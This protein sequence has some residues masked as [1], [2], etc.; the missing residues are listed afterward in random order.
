MRTGVCSDDS[1]RKFLEIDELANVFASLHVA[2]AFSVRCQDANDVKGVSRR[3]I[4]AFVRMTRR[5]IGKRN[6][7]QSIYTYSFFSADIGAVFTVGVSLF[8]ARCSKRRPCWLKSDGAGDKIR[9][10]IG[11]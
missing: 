7:G 3:T 10:D 9:F 4:K 5:V 1:S 2:L 8:R 11:S 6:V